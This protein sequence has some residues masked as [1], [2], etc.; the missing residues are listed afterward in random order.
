MYGEIVL[1]VVYNVYMY[2][3]AVIHVPCRKATYIHLFYSILSLF[4]VCRLI[5]YMYYYFSYIAGHTELPPG[6]MQQCHMTCGPAVWCE[7]GGYTPLLYPWFMTLIFNSFRWCFIH[8]HVR[9]CASVAKA[10]TFWGV[11]GLDKNSGLKFGNNVQS[12]WG[13]KHAW[14]GIWVFVHMGLRRLWVEG[15]IWKYYIFIFYS[16]L[17]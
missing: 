9:V 8:W 17:H 11:F 6:D 3:H 14:L 2:E 13:Y 1:N 4:W 5:F 12:I 10:P 16:I 15:Y 7:H